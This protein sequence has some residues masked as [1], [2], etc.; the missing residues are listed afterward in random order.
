MATATVVNKATEVVAAIDTMGD[1]TTTVIKYGANITVTAT[2]AANNPEV[3]DIVAE[4]TTP[5][6]G[7]WNYITLLGTE[8]RHEY[9][10]TR[11]VRL[12][13]NKGMH[14][15]VKAAE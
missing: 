5:K 10:M 13:D 8:V 9:F 15:T 12:P 7:A 11:A 2:H 14:W 4:I 3:V 6:P 1:F